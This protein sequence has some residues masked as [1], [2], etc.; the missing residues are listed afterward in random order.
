MERKGLCSTCV[1]VKA[2]IFIKDAPVWLCEEFSNGNHV[3][4]SFKQAKTKRVV[5][6]EVATESE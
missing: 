5:S 3:P 2:C 1:R 6:R 4:T